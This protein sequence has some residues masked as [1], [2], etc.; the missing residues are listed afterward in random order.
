MAFGGNMKLLRLLLTACALFSAITTPAASQEY[1]TKSIRFI[2]P[3]PAGGLVDALARLIAENLTKE[4]GQTVV[5]ENRPGGATMIGT[6][7]VINS[8]PDGYTLL[9]GNTNISINPN[10][11]KAMPYDAEKQ[12]L[13]VALI[14]LVPTLFLVHP[15]VP[16]KSI[17]DLIDLAKA[18]PGKLN[19]SHGGHGSFPHLA[20]ELFKALAKVDITPVPFT[21]A[22]P[23][24]T[25][26]LGK[27]VDLIDNDIPTALSHVQDGKLRALAITSDTRVK[28]LPDVPTMVEAGVPGYEAVA[29]QGIFVPAGT[30]KSIVDKLNVQ[31]VKALAAPNLRDIFSKQGLDGIPP[32]KPEEFGT[33]LKKEGVRWKGAIDAAGI[34]PE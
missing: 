7:A 26:L 10:L 28:T 32:W 8:P 5:V 1:P 15:D 19:Y 2:V 31:I 23:A 12:L 14:N 21:G 11:Q 29:W 17:K 24:L 9:L 20:V 25:A 18:N 6:Q 16:A 27:H 34:K 13:P 3:Y 22:A 30:P 4:W 33:F